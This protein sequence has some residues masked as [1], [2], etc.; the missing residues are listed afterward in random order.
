MKTNVILLLLLL[1]FYNE[2]S[3]QVPSLQYQKPLGGTKSDKGYCIAALADG[4]YAIA[5]EADSWNGNMT[6]NHGPTDIWLAKLDSSLNVIWQKSLGGSN[7]EG[8]NSILQTF[9]GGFIL[10]GYTG[11]DDGD[12]SGLH[13]NFSPLF[14]YWVVKTDSIG[15]IQWQKCLGGTFWDE[16]Y[17]VKQTT[18]SG[19]ILIGNAKSGDGDVTNHH[20]YCSGCYEDFWVV[21]L[22]SSGNIQW[23]EAYGASNYDFGMSI[24]QLSD[25]G[26]IAAGF[27]ASQ[28]S[29]VIGNHG[30]TDAWIL[31]L[32]SAG[33]VIWKYCYGGSSDD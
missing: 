23:E 18:D 7:S 4:T 2:N 9:D 19:Y 20:G 22:N 31:R 1:F 25:G 6:G 21:K 13:I 30:A 33:V 32:D 29:D 3:A 27:T 26:Y 16:G 8:A 11:S 14:D 24:A 15:N 28:D 12:V 17:E 10:L 5:G